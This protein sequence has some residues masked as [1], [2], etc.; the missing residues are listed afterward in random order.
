MRGADSFRLARYYTALGL[1]N[2]RR[3]VTAF[4]SCGGIEHFDNLAVVDLATKDLLNRIFVGREG[5]RRFRPWLAVAAAS[6][7]VSIWCLFVF[8]AALYPRRGY[9]SRKK[10][11]FFVFF[12]CF[13]YLTTCPRC[14]YIGDMKKSS[15]TADSRKHSED[16]HIRIEPEHKKLFLEAA[17]LE[18]LDLSSWIRSRLLKAARKD[19]K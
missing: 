7:A 5:M 15:K 8:I 19:L 3:G 6:G 16:L 4:V 14:G 2:G 10:R 12:P 9:M 1:G 13:F 18:G 17:E 11:M